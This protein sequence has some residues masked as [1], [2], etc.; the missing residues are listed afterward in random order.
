MLSKILNLVLVLLILGLVYNYIQKLP[1]LK[2]GEV[3][4]EFTAVL[5]NGDQF[6]LSELRGSYVLLHFWGS[7]CSPCRKS[8]V[9]LT[10]LYNE[11]QSNHFEDAET[12]EIVSIGIENSEEK[13]LK[14]IDKDMLL[15][16]YH[17]VQTQRFKSELPMLFGVKSIPTT[18]LLDPDG[19][20]L[21]S[22]PS[23]NV[24][25]DYLRSK[26]TAI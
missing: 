26:Q 12:F 4:P 18:Y 25:L 6:Q 8:N 19:N 9:D 3:P 23:Y 13:W 22:N 21:F 1:K 5:K 17:I 7:W 15:W 14:A 10:K 2:S 16:P 11:L 24:I 20:V